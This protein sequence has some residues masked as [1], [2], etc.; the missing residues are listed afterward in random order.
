MLRFFDADV[1][2][3]DQGLGVDRADRRPL[4]DL[5]IHEGLGVAGVVAFVVAVA[6]VADHVDHDIFVEALPKFERQLS[7]PYAGLRVVGVH[8][9]DRSL[10][11]LGHIG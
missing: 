10:N 5:A 7:H 8:V 4:G 11:R 2:S 9:E 3:V 1:A 6:P